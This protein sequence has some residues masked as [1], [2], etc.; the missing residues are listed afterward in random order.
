[1]PVR[2]SVFTGHFHAIR[3]PHTLRCFRHALISSRLSLLH[4]GSGKRGATVSEEYVVGASYT[5]ARR[6][7]LAS[8]P[9]KSQLLLFRVLKTF[10]V[11]PLWGEKG[12]WL[13]CFTSSL[14]A[15]AVKSPTERC[16]TGQSKPGSQQD[17]SGHCG[18]PSAALLPVW[19]APPFPK[20]QTNPSLMMVGDSQGQQASG[21]PQDSHTHIGHCFMEH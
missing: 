7:K 9:S 10:L 1:M 20:A 5:A 6:Q 12:A 13:C 3:R 2:L 8:S 21:R 15:P 16:L 11:A 19:R 14:T 18:S 4:C 17:L